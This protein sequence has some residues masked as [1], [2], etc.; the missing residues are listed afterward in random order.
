MLGGE[1]T[2]GRGPAASRAAI[3]L[4]AQQ[5]HHMSGL[6]LGPGDQSV[7]GGDERRGWRG[8]SGHCVRV[9]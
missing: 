1:S 7:A 3:Q 4:L 6:V 5:V 9:L 8:P 2:G